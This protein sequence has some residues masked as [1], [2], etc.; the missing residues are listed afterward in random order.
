VSYSSK[1]LVYNIVCERDPLEFDN[2]GAPK[3]HGDEGK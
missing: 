2:Y 3:G 1:Y